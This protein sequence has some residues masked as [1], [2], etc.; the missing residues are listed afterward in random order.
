MSFFYGKKTIQ[1]LLFSLPLFLFIGGIKINTQ[2]N[3]IRELKENIQ[4]TEESSKTLRSDTLKI[5]KDLDG[6]WGEIKRNTVSISD[7]ITWCINR[8]RGN[9]GVSDFDIEP[10]GANPPIE[11]RISRL[12][13]NEREGL[14]PC[15]APYKV[16][17]TFKETTIGSL[18]YIF[19]ELESKKNSAIIS[20]LSVEPL[21]KK[22]TFQANAEVCFPIF[23][24]P[25]DARDVKDFL[26]TPLSTLA[27]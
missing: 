12:L 5:R 25:E 17:L 26:S 14:W 18:L 10:I 21:D 27:K 3:E 11:M 2:R 22:G 16:N 24:Y 6:S 8:I 1:A 20:K 4:K 7:P 15:L 9:V 23:Y 19:E 13:R